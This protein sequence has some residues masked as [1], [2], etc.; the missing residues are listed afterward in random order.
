MPNNLKNL[1]T[2]IPLTS[3]ALVIRDAPTGGN[4]LTSAQNTFWMRVGNI[5]FVWCALDNIVIGAATPGNTVYIT[6]LPYQAVRTALG[7]PYTYRITQAGQ[8]QCSMG[9]NTGT[10]L[11]S[12]ATAGGE[13]TLKV[14][15]LL[16]PSGSS[17]GFTLS[18]PVAP[19]AA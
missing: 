16:S 18:Y 8:L 9:I 3:I 11:F 17:L 7:V 5:C 13:A 2:F 1:I 15:G 19:E 14:S 6:G 4:I 12:D 10:V